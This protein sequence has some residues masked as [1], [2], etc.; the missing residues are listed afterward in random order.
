M[1]G[2]RRRHPRAT[3]AAVAA[4][5]EAALSA[6]VRSASFEAPKSSSAKGPRGGAA[7]AMAAKTRAWD[8]SMPR[9]ANARS[10]PASASRRACAL[11]AGARSDRHHSPVWATAL[12]YASFASS[13]NRASRRTSPS[14]ERRQVDEIEVSCVSSGLAPHVL[15]VGRRMD[16]ISAHSTARASVRLRRR[17]PSSAVPA[18]ARGEDPNPPTK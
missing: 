10:S 9:A 1:S 12:A 16:A 4:A 14:A 5:A 18:A 13:R 3:A 17:L 6:P 15:R 8:D 2:S 7:A 11:H